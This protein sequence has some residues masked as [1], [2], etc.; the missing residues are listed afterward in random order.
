MSSKKEKVVSNETVV[1]IKSKLLQ[2]SWLYVLCFV[3][4]TGIIFH[5]FFFHDGMLFSSDQMSGFDAKVFLQHTL[6]EY[7][8]FPLWFNSRLSG[9][10]TIDAMFG[11][12]FYLPSVVIG[13]FFPIDRAISI[14]MILHVFLAGLFFYLL[15]RKGF[16]FPRLLAFSGGMFYM[17]NPQFFSHIYPGHDG[18]MYVIAWLP[19]VIW[20]LKSL[21]E[22]PSLIN[23]SL[24]SLGLGMSLLTSHIQMNYFVLWGL[25]LFW[26]FAVSLLVFKDHDLKKV[27]RLSAFFWFSVLVA[28]LLAVATL[29]PS[30]L[31]VHEAFSVRGVDR[32]F[33][34]AASWALGWADVFSLWVPEFVNTLDYYWGQNPFKLNSEYVGAI[35]LL[36]ASL[37]IAFKPGKWRIFWGAMSISACLYALGAH[38]PVFHVAYYLIPGVKRF[39]AASMIMFWF[40][41]GTVLL[42]SLFLKDLLAG[43]L[44]DLPQEKQR[45]WTRGL[46][47]VNAAIVLI[48]LILSS[49]GIV[50]GLFQG[51]LDSNKQRVFELNFSRNFVPALWLWFFGSTATLALLIAVIRGKLKPV[52]ATAV[53]VVLGIFDIYRVDTRF[54]KMTSTK[55]Y[56][57][58]DPV[59]EKLA[60][61]MDTAPFRCF[62]LPGSLPQNGEGIH[63]LEGIGGFHDN[64][65]KWYREFR[66]DQQDRNYFINILSFDVSGQPYLKANMLSHGNTFLD[67]ANVKYL[68]V[69]SQ[70]KLMA[71]ENKNALGRI[72]FVNKYTVMDSGSILNA[73]VNSQYNYRET[74]ALLQEPEI[75][76]ELLDS[77]SAEKF[78]VKWEKY[79]PNY[80]KARVSTPSGGFLRI[81]EVYYPGW[82]IR[83]DNKKVP[84]YQADLTWMAVPVKKGE[85][86][87]EIICH[88]IFLNRVM[89]ISLL[90]A[91]V[92]CVYWLTYAIIKRKLFKRG[93][94]L[95]KAEERAKK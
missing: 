16:R 26:V 53:I 34:F 10:P 15:L 29:I 50:S 38:T 1:S 7:H 76:P 60:K 3:F 71:I 72:S 14:K 45:R 24:V 81:S 79:T 94:V 17:L 42:A 93:V 49:K 66:G 22:V 44:S 20:R 52:H 35:V 88:S 46:L 61:E 74:V 68:L 87:I 58:S 91:L 95:L 57:Q 73:L 51:M 5:Q 92:L 9:M 6:R 83:I 27:F 11:D 47:I 54:I 75:K 86:E 19:F 37:S 64:E 2:S 8:Q 82:E 55:P 85:Y 43:K 25:F 67:L 63:S 39:R 65:L 41:F 40:S 77:N 90:T 4:V 28:L 80:R 56:F 70:G 13:Y 89:W 18:K 59:L 23:A 32:G 21:F 84:I 62:S 12:P 48:T 69:R 31:Y 78:S 33:D 36:L 30:Y